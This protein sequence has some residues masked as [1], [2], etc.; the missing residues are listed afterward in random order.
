MLEIL[1]NFESKIN[2]SKILEKLNLKEKTI[3]VSM[4]REENVDS[5]DNLKKFLNILLKIS[6]KFQ[7]KI[8]FYTFKNWKKYKKI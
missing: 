1:K 6:K 5:V 2:N 8:V 7:K 3:L 4:H